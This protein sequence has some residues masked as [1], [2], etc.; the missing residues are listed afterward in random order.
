MYLRFL[1]T[2]IL[3]QKIVLLS[4][5]SII[6]S[7][8]NK[9]LAS[10]GLMFGPDPSSGDVCK[11]GGMLAN[12]SSGPHTLRYGAVKDNVLSMRVCLESG[13]WL[14]AGV[15]DKESHECRQL[16]LIHI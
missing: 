5:G 6:E 9:Q 8:L 2:Y 11:L 3:I 13:G 10:S 1:T 7:S 4:D 15:A 14:T 12:N 16:S